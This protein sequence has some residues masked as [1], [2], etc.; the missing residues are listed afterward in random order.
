MH[1]DEK[2]WNPVDTKYTTWRP[3]ICRRPSTVV[4]QSSTDAW[5]DK[6]TGNHLF[7]RGLNIHKCKT[8]ILKVNAVSMEPVKLKLEWNEIVEVETFTY[9]ARIRKARGA[10]IQLKNIWSSKVLS[11]HTEISLTPMWSPY[12]CMEQRHG[13]Q[14][15][16]PPRNYRL[17]LIT[18]WE[19]SSKFAGQTPSV[20]ATCGRKHTNKILE[21]RWERDNGGG[22]VTHFGNQHQL[23]PGRP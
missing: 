5:E 15:T 13:G 11:L 22:F 6:W 8:K 16:P 18:V 2:K 12:Y 4:S 7:I 21:M 20:T 19:E 9:K 10:F 1:K 3:E 14:L 17:L 23:S